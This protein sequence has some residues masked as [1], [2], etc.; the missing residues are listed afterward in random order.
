MMGQI[1]CSIFVRFGILCYSD[2]SL[3]LVVKIYCGENRLMEEDDVGTFLTSLR[4]V[5]QIFNA[6]TTNN[7]K[8]QFINFPYLITRSFVSGL[9]GIWTTVV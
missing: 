3:I 6:V 5:E 9:K 7:Y 1:I 8:A 4:G 2:R